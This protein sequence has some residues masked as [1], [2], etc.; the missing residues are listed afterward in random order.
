MKTIQSTDVKSVSACEVQP[1]MV[2]VDGVVLEVRINAIGGVVQIEHRNVVYNENM[3]AQV[4]ILC[5]VTKPMV[6]VMTEALAVQ[7]V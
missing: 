1:G 5:K 2:T 6:G 4:Q 7:G 3:H